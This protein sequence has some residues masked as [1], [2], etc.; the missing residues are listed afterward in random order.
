M[1]SLSDTP[2]LAMMMPE[3]TKSGTAINGVEST[4]PTIWRTINSI[5][6]GNIGLRKCGTIAEIPIV[7]PTGTVTARQIANTANTYPNILSYLPFLSSAT[8]IK[9]CCAH[10]TIPRA[11]PTTDDP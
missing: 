8:F 4:P 1:K 10:L 3:R 5:L 2:P 9:T 11:K 6:A 7:M